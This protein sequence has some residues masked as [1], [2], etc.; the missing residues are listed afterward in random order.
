MGKTSFTNSVSLFLVDV[1]FGRPRPYSIR[2]SARDHRAMANA[3]LELLTMDAEVSW[4]EVN[5]MDLLK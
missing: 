2:M 3:L 4:S 1:A 5:P